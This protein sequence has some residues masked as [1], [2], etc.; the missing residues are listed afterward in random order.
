MGEAKV[1]EVPWPVEALRNNTRKHWSVK[2]RAVK[3]ARS[4]TKALC[5]EKPRIEPNPNAVIFVE[6][7]PQNY[8]MDVHNVSA[9][10]K[11]HVD[12]IADAMGIDDANFVVHFPVAYSGRDPVGKVV[13]RVMPENASDWP[14]SFVLAMAG[15]PARGVAS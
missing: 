13:F 14:T 1:I 15:V 8:R 3:S 4:A 9:A 5:L 6:Y 12:G 2:A 7:W 11:A 10:L